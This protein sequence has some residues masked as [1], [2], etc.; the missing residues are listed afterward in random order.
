MHYLRRFTHDLHGRA[1]FEPRLAIGHQYVTGLHTFDD[2]LAAA[3]I[4][5]LH[6]YGFDFVT[7]HAVNEVLVETA[8]YDGGR[9]HQRIL[10]QRRLNFYRHQQA[11]PELLAGVVE[12]GFGADGAGVGI[13]LVVDQGQVTFA[14]QV[15][16]FAVGVG[17][18]VGL[19]LCVLRIVDQALQ[20]RQHL[21]R[22][23]EFHG[24]RVDLGH[25]EQA[26]G[27]GHAQEIAFV[28]G[29][30][31]DAAGD[32]GADL[33]VGKLYLRR[34]DC[35][36]VALGGGFELVDQCLLL[37]VGLFGD[38]VVDAEQFVA[39]EV[40]QGDLQLRLAF[41]QLCAGLVEAGADRAVVDGGE[42]VACF[43][44]LAFLDEDFGEDAVYLWAYYDAV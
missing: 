10:I 6:L 35:G 23:R 7:I 40:D 28:D 41:A 1:G 44:E 30:N 43:D 37:V 29:A 3:L 21:L 19:D 22:Q 2:V 8:L 31:T 9:Y 32:R 38:A 34:V 42:Q 17:T 25:G 4:H 12:F 20:G 11:R 16:G 27:V 13:D 39:F 18:D 33:R 24:D 5:H 36:L 15:A 14:K 26:G